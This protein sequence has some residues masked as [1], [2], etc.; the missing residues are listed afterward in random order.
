MSGKDPRGWLTKLLYPFNKTLR[1]QV[2]DTWQR[3]HGTPPPW[4]PQGQR[5]AHAEQERARLLRSPPPIAGDARWMSVGEAKALAMQAVQKD[6]PCDFIELG[7]VPDEQA[8]ELIPVVSP[9]PGH[10]LTI[11]ATRAGKGAAQIVPN[12]ITYRGSMLVIDP[13]G[14]NYAM[15]H[16]H[17]RCFSRVVRVD[18]FRVTEGWDAEAAFSKFNPMA[19][20]TDTSAARRLATALM[21]DAPYG[22]GRFWHQEALNFLTGLLLYNV[23]TS[24]RPSLGQFRSF[25]AHSEE[26]LLEILSAAAKTT[27]QPVVKAAFNRFVGKARKERSGVLSHVNAE[28]ALWDEPAMSET[29]S[30]SHFD[31]AQMR[32]DYPLTVYVILPFDKLY[33]HSAFLKLFVAQF[34]QT[35]I[36]PAKPPKIP[37]LCLIDEFPALGRMDELVKSLGEVAGYGVRL[38]LFAQGL[39]QIKSL[40]PGD[41]QTILAQCATQSYFGVTDAITAQEL[42]IALGRRT[43]AFEVPKNSHSQSGLD[44]DA[45]PQNNTSIDVTLDFKGM[46]LASPHEIRRRLGVGRP[47]QVVFQS[48]HDPIAARLF[49]WYEDADLRKVVTDLRTAPLNPPSKP[50][51]AIPKREPR[52]LDEDGKALLKRVTEWKGVPEGHQFGIKDV[53]DDDA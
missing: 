10:L 32:G 23:E 21:G 15:T 25:M 45:Y 41:W 28:T 4:T 6:R 29:V 1:K 22:D 18:P 37:V 11:A 13:K 27:K 17:R 24:A 43:I 16:K 35:M 5:Y 44:A 53:K 3:Q 14:E 40:Y 19:L 20:V 8:Q 47:L 38:W 50:H 9:A 49:P 48:G 31:F 2:N 52:E 51:S 33:T 42:S 39:N 26:D 46:P 36:M 7:Y 34:Y 30:E 12:L